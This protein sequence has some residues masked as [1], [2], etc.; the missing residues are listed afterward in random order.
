MAG[1][2]VLIQVWVV[3]YECQPLAGAKV[4]FWQADTDGIY[5]NN[6]YILRGHVIAS[7]DGL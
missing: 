7:E 2:P 4:D 3:N 1:T 6:G 5:D